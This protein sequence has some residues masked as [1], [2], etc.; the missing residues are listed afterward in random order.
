VTIAKRCAVVV[1]LARIAHQLQRDEKNAL[2]VAVYVG[3]HTPR[4]S[5]L[6]LASERVSRWRLWRTGAHFRSTLGPAGRGY[7]TRPKKNLYVQARE[8]T[9][10]MLGQVDRAQLFYLMAR[11]LSRAEAERIIVRGFFQDILDRIDL[12]PVRETLSEALEARIPKAQ[13]WA[14]AS[15]RRSRSRPRAEV[16][17][18]VSAGCIWPRGRTGWSQPGDSFLVPFELEKD[19]VEGVQQLRVGQTGQRPGVGRGSG[20]DVVVP[21]LVRCAGHA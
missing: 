7:T 20:V 8:A 12:E 18:N 16:R 10:A 2:T 1:R 11:G 21:R 5:V 13:R 9:K 19:A 4:G 3:Q 17:P 6:A 14:S 15:T